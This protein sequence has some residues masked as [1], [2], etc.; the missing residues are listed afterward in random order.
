MI[1]KQL[2]CFHVMIVKHQT[3]L[4]YNNITILSPVGQALNIVVMKYFGCPASNI[5]SM[6]TI[7]IVNY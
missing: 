4:L 6:F 1:V 2:L 5:V 3:S 7:M